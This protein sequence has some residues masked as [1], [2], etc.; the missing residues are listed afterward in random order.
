MPITCFMKAEHFVQCRLMSCAIS[1]TSS[2]RGS[3]VKMLEWQA[4]RVAI[5]GYLDRL[6]NFHCGYPIVKQGTHSTTGEG[7]SISNVFQ[8]FA[9]VEITV[10]CLNLSFA[11]L[12]KKSFGI[13]PSHMF[14]PFFN[15][16]SL[17][18]AFVYFF[19]YFAR[20]AS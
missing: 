14:Y 5:L 3:T 4:M 15:P 1:P 2:L 20:V 19:S 12:T 13:I 6:V 11:V 18:H 8:P 17:S 7:S 9:L 16:S 10:V